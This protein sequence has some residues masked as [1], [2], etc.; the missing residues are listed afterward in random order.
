MQTV[1]VVKRV[2]FR[3]NQPW[4]GMRAGDVIENVGPGL[5][6]ALLRGFRGEA[7]E[8]AGGGRAGGDGPVPQRNKS[9]SARQKG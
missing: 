6:D 7:I 4:N 8:E 3:L 2:R 9:L 5:L 1:K